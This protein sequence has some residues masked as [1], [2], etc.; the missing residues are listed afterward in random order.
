[1]TKMGTSPSPII[2]IES[3]SFASGAHLLL[4]KAL[5]DL[6]PGER[7]GVRVVGEQEREFLTHL[8]GWCRAQGHEFFEPEPARDETSGGAAVSAW[9]GRGMAGASGRWKDAERAGPGSWPSRW[10]RRRCVGASPRA[11]R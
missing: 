7:L 10:I 8:R 11:E 1:M 3:L 5:R 6:P 2:D 4:K 9:I